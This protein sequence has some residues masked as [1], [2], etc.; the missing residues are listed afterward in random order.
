MLL[1]MSSPAVFEILGYKHIGVT[2]LTYRGS[3]IVHVTIRFPTGHFLLVVLWN[4]ASIT[5]LAE[6]FNG[7]CCAM[8]D[9]TTSSELLAFV[10]YY[11]LVFFLTV[12]QNIMQSDNCNN[13]FIHSI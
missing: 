11:N 3:F 4:Q 9:M 7:E 6:I 8:A 1:N 12:E 13:N 2:S 10:N 5:L